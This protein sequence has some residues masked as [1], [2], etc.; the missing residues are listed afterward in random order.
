MAVD[1]SLVVFGN[2]SQIPIYKKYLLFGLLET[3]GGRLLIVDFLYER[4]KN[5]TKTNCVR[6]I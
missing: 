4:F 3:V 6:T 2:Y 5:D 1:Q